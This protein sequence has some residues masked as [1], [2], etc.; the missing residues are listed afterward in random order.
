MLKN[1]GPAG[2]VLALLLLPILAPANE[3]LDEAR[4]LI[5]RKQFGQAY[6]L[7]EPLADERAGNPEFDYLLGIAALDAG[8]LTE[9][10]F[11]LER[12]LSVEP[13]NAAARAELARAHLNLGELEQAKYEFENVKRQDLPDSVERTID[14]YLATIATES[15]RK[16]T[17][18]D[19]FLQTGL[20]Y[21][22][23]VNSATDSSQVAVPALGGLLLS[24]DGSGRSADSPIWNIAAGFDLSTPVRQSESLRFFGGMLYNQRIALEESDFSTRNI[25]VNGGFHLLHDNHQFRLAAQAQRF[26][27][28]G[29]PNRDLFGGTFQWQYNLSPNTQATLFGQA[30]ALRYPGQEVR[31]ANRYT[32]GLGFA[33]AFK[34]RGNPILFVSGYGGI[35]DEVENR[36]QDIGRDLYGFRVGGQFS[37]TKR[38]VGYGNFIYEDSE[39]G[40]PDPLFFTTREDELLDFTAGV[41]YALDR[42]WSIRPEVRYIEN[43]STLVINDY[44]RVSVMVFIRNDF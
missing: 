10:V 19:I 33:H 23:N 5:Q 26:Y 44:D 8:H 12:V 18:Y 14:D 40:A 30:A 39:Y 11:A 28:D 7:L 34:T 32:G 13:D 16:R 1:I 21:D 6:S 42:H 29:K 24:L 17:I 25:D 43:D 41:R 15:S 2:G 20:G 38:L 22:D 9:A 36:R 27:V 3:T 37:M 31:D 4:N 35:E